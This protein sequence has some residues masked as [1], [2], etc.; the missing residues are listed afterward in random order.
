MGRI[1]RGFLR[2]GGTLHF[3]GNETLLLVLYHQFQSTPP[4]FTT[5]IPLAFLYIFFFTA[6]YSA[7]TL[8]SNW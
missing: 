4:P 3:G 2:G 1:S 7:E 6:F 8:Q 5:H